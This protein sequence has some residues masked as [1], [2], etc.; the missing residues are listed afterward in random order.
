[1]NKE[2]NG[3]A[4]K[5]RVRGGNTSRGNLENHLIERRY[6]EEGRER[7]YPA[8][9]YAVWS[10]GR[11]EDTENP[12][13]KRDSRIRI[14]E[15]IQ[16]RPPFSD[17][18]REDG[19]SVRIRT[20]D[21]EEYT[22][23]TDSGETSREREWEI[24]AR[25]RSGNARALEGRN[26]KDRS[27]RNNNGRKSVDKKVRRRP[28][29]TVAVAIKGE[30]GFSYADALKKART[31][32]SLKEMGIGTTKIRRATNG[33]IIIEIPG[34][35]NKAKANLLVQK[36][37]QI[38]S[39]E[40]KVTRPSIKGELRVVGFDESVSVEEI[41]ETIAADGECEYDETSVSD[42]R[43]M[44]NGLY[45]TWVRCPL[46]AA[47]RIANNGRIKIGWSAVRVELLEARPKQCYKC[48]EFGH[49]KGVCRSETDRSALCFKC[50][51]ENHSYKE[52]K[53][54]L[55]CIICAQEGSEANHRI[56][57]FRCKA[58][59]RSVSVRNHGGNGT[60]SRSPRAERR[61]ATRPPHNGSTDTAN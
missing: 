45:M 1:M 54:E 20:K 28:P 41:K 52:C 11:N 19:I 10:S 33:G 16:I 48:W 56:G 34:A 23:N 43:P 2:T 59:K 5:E 18:E 14:K 26:G 46:A 35:E 3:R 6:N 50:G 30:E 13:P 24:V 60:R 55:H 17:E 44:R 58:S 42:I 8:R 9:E 12:L 32:I 37:K 27:Y 31:E 38:L 4:V 15:D 21:T 53:N 51:K 25:G 29:K 36:L 7:K 49:T 47:T 57:S 40:T 22:G 61:S 39:A